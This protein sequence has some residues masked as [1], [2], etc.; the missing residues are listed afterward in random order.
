MSATRVLSQLTAAAVATTAL[1]TLTSSVAHAE[2]TGVIRGTVLETG[3]VIAPG[4]DVSLYRLSG[5]FVQATVADSSAGGYAFTGLE[6]GSYILWFENQNEAVS[7]WYDNQPDKPQATPITLGAGQTYVADAYLTQISENLA[8]PTISGTPTVGSVLTA[9]RGTWYPTQGVEFS[10]QWLRD[11]AVI[12]GATTSTYRLRDADGGHRISV[13]SV[14][15]VQGATETATSASTALV[16]GGTAPVETIANVAKPAISGSTTVGSVLT[17]TPGS[18]TPADASVT[19]QW[20]RGDTVVGTGSSYTTATQ[21]IGSVLRVRA[22][23]S[24]SGWTAGVAESTDF[25]PITS[26]APVLV[27]PVLVTPPTVSGTARVGST[28]TATTG[29]WSTAA[30]HAFRWTRNGKAISGATGRSHRLT[31]AD[32]RA[33][34]AVVVTAS[35]PAGGA[36]AT[37]AARPVARATTRLS[38]SAKPLRK[39]R[40]KVTAKVTSQGSRT[41]RVTITVKSGGKTK[42][43]RTTLSRGSR[44]LTIKGL[45]K[46]RAT[47]RVVYAG[48]ASTSGASLTRKTT[49]R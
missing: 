10:H 30:S 41:G 34:I 48:D 24:R 5:E 33:R 22:T 13:R 20:L 16:T 7:E 21:D 8:V 12:A 36:S 14:A 6:P 25:G 26:A 43:V 44:T 29:S 11:G 17:A 4:I 42:V 46:G 38:A 2:A 15:M 37:S 18:W 47:V 32:A 40:L 9:S 3:H 39:G 28:L 1:A 45:R 31:P 49:V 27:A 19:L 23:A 35:N